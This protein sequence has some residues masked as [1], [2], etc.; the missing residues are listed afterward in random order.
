MRN[1]KIIGCGAALPENTVKFGDN[2]RYRMTNGQTLLDLIERAVAQALS[3]AGVTIND[4]DLILGGTATPLQG[5][6]CNA[7]L[8][9]ERI[10]KGSSIPAFDINSSCTSFITAFDMASYLIDAGR[11]KKILIF[12]GDTASAALNPNQKES[13][14]L[15]SDAAAAFVVTR[16]NGDSGVIGA[17]QCTYSEGVHD[18]EIRG[19]CGLLPSFALTDKNREDYYFD[20]KGVRVLKLT[21]KKVPGF[22]DD[23]L[24]ETGITLNDVDMFIPH[25]ASKALSLIMKKLGI[26]ED[27]YIDHVRD[28]G[29]MISAA[30]PMALYTAINENRIKRGDKVVM[31][32]T[33]AGLTINI[34]LM[35]Y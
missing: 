29:N 13:F 4:I 27:K 17:K 5:I 20:M 24:R 8:V 30:V 3:D 19:G 9:H 12:S 34:L 18:T 14:E 26:P 22:L 23:F 2:I 11:Y 21:A 25:Q 35:Q 7:A 15:F 33:A 31:F 6:P 16:G 32:G 28:W 1:I 10:A